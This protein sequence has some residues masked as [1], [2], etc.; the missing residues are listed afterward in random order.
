M[1]QISER[2]YA[3]SSIFVPYVVTIKEIKMD[4]DSRRVEFDVKMQEK[5]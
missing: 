4:A 2:C 1:L 5:K 3:Y